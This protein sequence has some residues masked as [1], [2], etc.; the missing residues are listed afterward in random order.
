MTNYY[1]LYD[2]GDEDDAAEPPKP[3]DTEIVAELEA[4]QRAER[5]HPFDDFVVRGRHL[6][7]PEVRAAWSRE[8]KRRAAK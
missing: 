5:K 8:L 6:L 1:L 2:P 3:S 7:E 4:R